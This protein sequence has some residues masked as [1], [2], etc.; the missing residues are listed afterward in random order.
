MTEST[1]EG[2]VEMRF[3]VGTPT[4]DALMDAMGLDPFAYFYIPE[5]DPGRAP[6][7]GGKVP[8]VE[9]YMRYEHGAIPR[10]RSCPGRVGTVMDRLK[11]MSSAELSRHLEGSWYDE[12]AE[13]TPEMWDSL[14]PRCRVMRGD[15][16]L[17]TIP[18]DFKG[19]GNARQFRVGG[20]L[21]MGAQFGYP[22]EGLYVGG[23]CFIM[24]FKLQWSKDGWNAEKVLE[25]GT[26]DV[27]L[28]RCLPGWR[29][30]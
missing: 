13:V 5:T 8:S 9:P 20:E 29:D 16:E 22:P 25:A 24:E 17:G 26:L 19:E 2:K 4:F 7:T 21:R 30:G 10:W 18:R 27:E 12:E 3:E 1:V 11:G 14:K 23:N 6:A 28:L 15:A